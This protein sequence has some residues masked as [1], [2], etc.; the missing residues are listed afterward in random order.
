M[1]NQRRIA[2]ILL[3]TAVTS[4]ACLSLEPP[5]RLGITPTAPATQTFVPTATTQPTTPTPTSTITPTFTVSPTITPLPPLRLDPTGPG[6]ATGTPIIIS[7]GS[8]PASGFPAAFPGAPGAGIPSGTAGGG[9]SGSPLSGEIVSWNCNGDEQMDFVPPNPV[10]GDDIYITVTSKTG[11]GYLQLQGSLPYGKVG[12]GLGGPGFYWQWKKAAD[13]V[14][15][16]VFDFYSGPRPEYRCV[17]NE[18][19]V[20]LAVP[21][22]ATATP[23]VLPTPTPSATPRP[24]H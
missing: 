22:T 2:A 23:R 5:P 16:L 8:S 15:K 12:E 1:K 9:S 20:S 19:L 17:R 24:D 10:V 3:V 7:P 18:I 21:P 6:G 11:H 4:V 13:K 14:G